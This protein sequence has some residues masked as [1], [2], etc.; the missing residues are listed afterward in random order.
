MTHRDEKLYRP[1]DRQPRHF[2]DTRD[3]KG[4]VACPEQDDTGGRRRLI[5]GR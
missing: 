1:S 4:Q 2:D 3:A 5:K